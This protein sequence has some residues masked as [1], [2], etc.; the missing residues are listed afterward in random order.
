MEHLLIPELGL[1]FV[2]SRPG[3]EYVGKPCR[4]IRLDAL[5]HPENK[6]R[7]RFR[8]RMA[9]VLR[10]EGVAAL[11]EAK[12]AMT[13]WRAFITPMWILTVSGHRRRWRPDVC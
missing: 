1:A 3:M 7:L 13:G 4:R 12:A 5:A 11:Q 2:T 10:E 8:R 9:D 6:A